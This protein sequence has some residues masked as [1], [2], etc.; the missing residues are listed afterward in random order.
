MMRM[1]LAASASYLVALAV[2]WWLARPE[3]GLLLLD[4]PGERSLHTRPTPRTGGLAVLAG[5]L[6]G[7]ALAMWGSSQPGLPWMLAGLFAVAGVSFA[8]DRR[9][10]SPFVR[11]SVHFLGA[12]LAVTSE[13]VIL[14][15]VAPGPP[16]V[17]GALTILGIVWLINLYNFMDGMD[18]FAGGM[19]VLGFVALALMAGPSRYPAYSGLCLTV[20]AASAG[21]LPFNFPPSRIF[22]GD[23][24][25]ATLG[26]L[27][28]GCIALGASMGAFPVESGL[29]VFSPFIA[30]ATITLLRR[31]FRR[32]RVWTAHRSH[33]YQRLVL[34]GWSHRRTVLWEYLLMSLAGASAVVA[35]RAGGRAP[36]LAVAA[37]AVIYVALMLLLERRLRTAPA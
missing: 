26:Y 7:G 23:V 16:V 25:S 27:A 5:V 14:S 32:E 35:E 34:S 21:F 15:R 29:L 10:V 12:A 3:S 1:V 28:A 4:H 18:G 31:G 37:W 11:L 19:T 33:Y 22:L 2:T 17:S 24:G 20:A 30:D 8:D 6:G 36:W 13:L 9:G